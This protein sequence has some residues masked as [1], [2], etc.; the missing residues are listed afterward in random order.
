MGPGGECELV[1]GW[2]ASPVATDCTGVEGEC[3]SDGVLGLC[4]EEQCY[5]TDCEGLQDGTT[6]VNTYQFGAWLNACEA[7]ECVY[8]EDCT[9]IADGVLCVD[10]VCN[11][12][13][14][15]KSCEELEDGTECLYYGDQPEDQPTIGVC[16]G[17]ECVEQ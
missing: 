8:P 17:D 16:E 12:G 11:G 15:Y 13:T 2:T 9:G 5:P 10:G 3:R 4:F 6:C 1:G 7:G 14:C